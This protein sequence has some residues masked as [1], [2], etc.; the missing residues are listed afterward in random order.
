MAKNLTI[1]LI[2]G[3]SVLILVSFFSNANSQ[4]PSIPSWIKNNAKYW[5]E[6]QIQDSE[7]VKGIEYLI[8]QGIM[9][10][11]QTKASQSQSTGI[12]SWIKN[13]A[14]YWSEDQITN[15]EFVK[16]IEYLVESGIIVTNTPTD[17]SQ[18]D[19][20]L[21]DH[22]YHPQRLNILEL[23]TQVSG[24]IKAIA[25][26]P[27][28]DYQIRLALDP[29]YKFMINQANV[30]QQKGHMV[31]E[32][33]CQNQ[34]DVQDAV[35]SCQ[36]FTGTVNIPPVGTHVVVTGSYVLDLE[37]DRLAEI[38]PVSSI[39]TILLNGTI[40]YN[41]TA[42]AP[43]PVTSP[44]SK[45]DNKS[46]PLHIDLAERDYIKRGTI[47]AMTVEISD[48]E[49]PISG[50]QVKVHVTYA[51]G[52]TTK[53]FTGVTDAKGE[54]NVSWTIGADSP[55]GTFQVDIGATKDGFIQTN[56]SFTFDVAS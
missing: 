35:Q 40:Y 53:D 34:S 14:K 46:S 2:A 18:C 7:F 22:V 30:D 21:W 28:G 44:P 45:P 8:N 1:S 55:P 9:Q 25:P 19:T 36:G 11:P 10:I 32:T 47:Q 56:R 54:F 12:P 3:L 42:S 29:N 49:N 6:G 33:I 23:C 5:S 16:G 31:L 51:S 13:N 48:G 27:N 39:G 17:Q 26:Q 41:K 43:I 50:A 4:E 52:Y 38:H 24:I 20:T 15:S 37:H